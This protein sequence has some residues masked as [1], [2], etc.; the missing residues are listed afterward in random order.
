MVSPMVW[1]RAV[2][3]V[4]VASLLTVASAKDRPVQI[5]GYVPHS[6]DIVFQTSASQ[7]G[8]AIEIATGSK[9]T[10]CGIVLIDSDTTFVYEAVGPVRKITLEEW[11]TRGVENK[12]AVKRLNAADSTLLPE[13][14]DKMRAVF[15]K[16]LGLEYDIQFKWS[17]DRFYCSELVYKMFKEG[18]DIEIGEFARFGDFKLDDPLVRFWIEKYFPDGPNMKE[19]VVSPISIYNDTTLVTVHSTY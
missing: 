3:L 19:K 17:D 10:H 18:A 7:L 15:A 2:S 1:I 12:F 16:Y 5:E 6:G 11:I 13:A 4:I 9:I 14:F 8:P